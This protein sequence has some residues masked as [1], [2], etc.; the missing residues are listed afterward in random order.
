MLRP[1]TSS[2]GPQKVSTHSQGQAFP[3]GSLALLTVQGPSEGSWR[4]KTQDRENSQ[5][6]VRR[7]C[8]TARRVW[9]GPRWAL[10]R[11][12]SRDW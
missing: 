3:P 8:F 12:F 10:P 7:N 6:N 5:Q 11:S 9:V 1:P 4:P 2:P